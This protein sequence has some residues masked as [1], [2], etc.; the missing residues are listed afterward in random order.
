MLALGLP[1]ANPALAA[2]LA[3]PGMHRSASSADP[4]AGPIRKQRP[5]SPVSYGPCLAVT[6]TAPR[7]WRTTGFRRPALAPRPAFF[8]CRHHPMKTLLVVGFRTLLADSPGAG[9]TTCR[10][11]T[12]RT[13]TVDVPTRRIDLLRLLILLLCVASRPVTPGRTACIE[14]RARRVA[15]R[16]AFT[17]LLWMSRVLGDVRA[18]GATSRHGE[19]HGNYHWRNHPGCHAGRA[20]WH[21]ERGRP[22]ID[23]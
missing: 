22:Y 17:H 11:A 2:G 8:L 15:L 9:S 20:R 14:S 10:P 18:I 5:A 12:A 4:V 3:A 7:G 13:G 6:A 16:R 23:Q 19:P 1:R 21:E